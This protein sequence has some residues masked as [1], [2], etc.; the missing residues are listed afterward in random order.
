MTYKIGKTTSEYRDNEQLLVT[1]E[2]QQQSALSLAMK[3]G[4]LGSLVA[5]LVTDMGLLTLMVAGILD[6]QTA[7]LF[8]FPLGLL[9][10]FWAGVSVDL[11]RVCA[12]AVRTMVETFEAFLERARRSMD[13]ADNMIEVK[14]IAPPAIEK[15]LV[16]RPIVINRPQRQPLP[17]SPPKALPAN[18]SEFT[19]ETPQSGESWLDQ[20]R[21]QVSSTEADVPTPEAQSQPMPEPEALPEPVPKMVQRYVQT[22]EGPLDKRDLARFAAEMFDNGWS[23]AVWA[24]GGKSKKVA[25][26]KRNYTGEHA[27]TVYDRCKSL[28]LQIGVFEK[29]ASK[30]SPMKCVFASYDDLAAHLSKSDLIFDGKSG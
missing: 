9:T 4:C 14:P 8:W 20:I 19:Y 7:I 13:G 1:P 5:F 18:A 22:S 30:N 24:G 23:Q 15:T 28:F 26:F 12:L 16:D 11:L 29:G 10:L 27:R 17:T 21:R 3:A 2:P 6:W 25:R